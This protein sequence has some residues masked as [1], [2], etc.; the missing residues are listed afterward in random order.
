LTVKKKKVKK[1]KVKSKQT[2]K[3]PQPKAPAAAKPW[4]VTKKHKL[5]K[6]EFDIKHPAIYISSLGDA[7]ES[8]FDYFPN[9]NT[10]G[11]SGTR[12]TM[13]DSLKNGTY[14]PNMSTVPY[15]AEVE[16][17]NNYLIKAEPKND[18]FIT[19]EKDTFEFSAEVYQKQREQSYTRLET[20]L[21]QYK[22][23]NIP[24]LPRY[25]HNPLQYYDH[26][27]LA[28]AYV[29]SF[30]G[31]VIDAYTDF[32]MPKTLKPVLKL[33][34]PKKHGDSQA[35]QKLIEKHQDIIYKLTQVDDWYSDM[36]PEEIDPYMDMP[37]QIKFKA[38]ITQHLTFGR[39]AFVYEHWEHLPHVTVDGIEYKDIPNAIKL[40]HPIDMGMI[41]LDEYTWKL[42]GMYIYNQPA[43][44]PSID[45]LYLVNRYASPLIGSFYYGFAM[46][47]RSIDPVRVY[48]RILA[49]NYQ[50][51]IRSS[52]SGMGAFV[53]D[54]TGYDEET[55]KKIRTTIINSYKSGEIAVI[56]YANI[57]DFDFKEMKINADI[58]GLVTV[59]EAMVK[60]M[61][62]VTGMPQSLIYGE[63]D[64]NRSTL[65][66]RI[67]SFI[68]NQIQQLRSSI[69]AQIA[70]QHYMPNFRTLY[71]GQKELDLF[72][73]D[74]EFEEAE[75]ETRSEKVERLLNEMELFPYKPEHIG[76]EL[77]DKDYMTNIDDDAIK[78][79]QEQAKQM[80]EGGGSP[81]GQGNSSSKG[82]FTV[83][84]PGGE[85]A[86]VTQRN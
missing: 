10:Q 51:F 28:D 64:A 76:E 69:G 26:I 73:I 40:L 82:V 15:T 5:N 72:Y 71:K 85:T 12:K 57:K 17:K 35:Q 84:G 18:D 34:N 14:Q 11:L 78:Q 30:Q 16:K 41:E 55:R 25:Y 56:D 74:V 59:Q 13:I 9:L 48:R 68:N 79:K 29:N 53:F 45:M 60:I 67:V 19:T 54:S 50:Q 44:V 43:F 46:G 7:K 52:H 1:K 47:Q 3:K 33:R 32:I 42:G 58:Q 81:F 62:G 23:S 21:K 4:I 61:I 83:K 63:G 66:G 37:L 77:G 24:L 75:L 49:Q 20:I 70:S 65:V 80:S 36:G 6:E 2:R 22:H 8:E 38:L 27:L 39:C 31:T 86:K